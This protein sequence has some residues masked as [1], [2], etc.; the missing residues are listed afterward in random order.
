[1]RTLGMT[2]DSHLAG[3]TGQLPEDAILTSRDVD[4]NADI[5]ATQAFLSYRS[6]LDAEHPARPYMH[7]MGE[8]RA[9][10]G[11]I[12]CGVKEVRFAEG[13]GIPVDILYEFG[14]GELSEMVSKGLYD[15]GFR[16]PSI[17]TEN[18]LEMPVYCDFKVVAPQTEAD[19]PIVFADISDR[20]CIEVSEETCGYRFGDYFEEAVREAAPAYDDFEAYDGYAHDELFADDY[21]PEAEV[22]EESARELT[23]HEKA[24]EEYYANIRARVVHDH[25]LRKGGIAKAS[26]KERVPHKELKAREVEEEPALENPADE[27]EALARDVAAEAV[28]KAPAYGDYDAERYEADADFE[29]DVFEAESDEEMLAEQAEDEVDSENERQAAIDDNVDANQGFDDD[30]ED[31]PFE[32]VEPEPDVEPARYEHELPERLKSIAEGRPDDFEDDSQFI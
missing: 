26:E 4:C 10:R 9:I 12:P 18:V 7:I 14:N 32:N 22:E 20:R 15:A 27:V 21:V 17:I 30:F 2:M 8:C 29:E 3:L 19:V 25:I 16:C 23:D 28:A 11:E 24:V 13:E 5:Y 31:A 1:M 6:P